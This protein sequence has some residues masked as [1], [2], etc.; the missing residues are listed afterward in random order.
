MSYPGLG[1]DQGKGR[2]ECLW[3]A[4]AGFKG[5]KMA[6]SDPGQLLV[7]RRGEMPASQPSQ[8]SCSEPE[9]TPAGEAEGQD[10]CLRNSCTMCHMSLIRPGITLSF[11]QHTLS[12]VSGTE[13]MAV[14]L[15]CLI[16]GTGFNL[17][18]RVLRHPSGN[19][20]TDGAR[21]RDS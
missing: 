21:L 1:Q 18:F 11:Y 14:H 20:D 12:D 9:A 4:R 8:N 10:L 13:L 16:A 2:V 7:G 17:L 5:S 19:P 15:R 3:R 6:V